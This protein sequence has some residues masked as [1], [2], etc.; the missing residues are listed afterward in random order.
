MANTQELNVKFKVDA[1]EVTK[2]SNDAKSKVKDAATQMANDVKSSSQKMEQSFKDVA[3]STDAIKDATKTAT[4]AVKTMETQVD[5]S[6]KN[7][8]KSMES[9]SKKMSA[10]MVAHGASTAMRMAGSAVQSFGPTL[11]MD[12]GAAKTTGSILTGAASGINAGAQLGTVIGGPGMGTAIGAAAGG[13]M[14]AASALMTAGKELQDAAKAQDERAK[15]DLET[16]RK[17]IVHQNDV[18]KWTKEANTLAYNAYGNGT[19]FGTDEGKA[20]LGQSIADQRRRIANLTAQRDSIAMNYDENGDVFAQAEKMRSLDESI[21]FATE[22][23]NIFL[24][25][26]QNAA[27]VEEKA[28]AATE[29][30]IKAAEDAIEAR[31]QEAQNIR[32]RQEEA[33][34]KERQR[35]EAKAVKDAEDAARAKQKEE[36]KNLNGKLREGEST[37]ADLQ[38]QLNGVF[39]GA[40]TPSDS[41]TKMGGGVGYTSYNNSVEGVQKTIS[42]NLKKLIENQT[43]Q[44]QEII[45]RLKDLTGGDGSTF[46]Q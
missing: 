21:A 6:A 40:S 26:A 25:A 44:N 42:D 5:S 43:N 22:K 29:A 16:R 9:V 39:K 10:M 34:A 13:L 4:T 23:L 35:Q 12:E 8:E 7:M 36:E 15:S 30:G 24:Q 18:N 28:I 1:S 17:E 11:G 19:V 33:D 2:G 38:S 14:G 3:K 46:Q 32:R 37:L 20:A 45:D 31:K 27:D 41:L